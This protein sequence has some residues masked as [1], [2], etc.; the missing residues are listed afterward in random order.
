M[1]DQLPPPHPEQPTEQEIND[2][3]RPPA[4]RFSKLIVEMANRKFG[5]LSPFWA[6][7]IGAFTVQNVLI[8]SLLESFEPGSEEGLK[9]I[10]T[11]FDQCK[12]ATANH[13]RA[14]GFVKQFSK[15]AK[16]SSLLIV[17]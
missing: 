4:L 6:P 1:R 8:I 14:P 17:P 12:F 7:L 10:N 5:G 16:K 11:F 2:Q 3:C 15:A 9:A 13:W